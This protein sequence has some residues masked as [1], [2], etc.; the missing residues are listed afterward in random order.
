MTCITRW[1]VSVGGG[2]DY[3]L[4]QMRLG[5]RGGQRVGRLNA[6]RLERMF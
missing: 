5:A 2:A 4:K 1:R 6:S 3:A